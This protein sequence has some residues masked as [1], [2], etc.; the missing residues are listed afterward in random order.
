MEQKG[1]VKASVNLP[2][3]V[4]D[5]YRSVEAME[6]FSQLLLDSKLCPDHF[7]EKLPDNKPDYTKGKT[8]AVMMVLLQGHQLNLPP[9]TALQHVIPVNGLLSIKG[10]AAKTLIFNS[11]KLEP[12]TWKEAVTG[13]IAGGDYECTMTARRSDTKEIMSRSFGIVHAKRAGLWVDEAKVRGNDGWKYQKSAWYKYP[14]RMMA[15]RA[16]G[17]LARDLFPD[18]LSGIYTTEEAIDMPVDT[19]EIIQTESGANV[20]IPDK[21]FN[22]SRSE[23]LTSKANDQID[24]RAGDLEPEPKKEQYPM[25]EEEATPVTQTDPEARDSTAT[26]LNGTPGFIGVYTEEELKVMDSKDLTSLIECDGMMVKAMDIDPAKNTNKK[27]RT[28]LLAHYAGDVVSLIAKFDPEYS[29]KLGTVFP[30]KDGAPSEPISQ[31]P[32]PEN[33]EIPM[34]AVGDQEE[35][36]PDGGAEVHA[37]EAFDASAVDPGVDTNKFNIDVPEL[38]DGKRSFEQV[39]VLYEEMASQAG[40]DNKAFESLITNK[41]PQFQHYRIKEDFCYK[42]PTSE[43]NTLLNSI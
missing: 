7:Y 23:D 3:F 4:E 6:K 24:K 32:E 16:L 14:E 29:A 13:S 27:L 19:E 22:K 12:A 10:D 20:V 40:L 35:P 11:G 31:E 36:E 37:N 1:L 15:Y 39:K 8:A 30:E 21:G 42:A 17:F 9:L 25:T 18:V 41:F 26:M 2:G 38:V 5:A 43:I 28:I 33:E 34:E